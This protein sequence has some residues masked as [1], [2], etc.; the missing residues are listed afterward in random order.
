[1]KLITDERLRNKTKV[2]E[3]REHAGKILAEHVIRRFDHAQGV[4]AIPLGGIPVA[5]EVMSA[6]ETRGDIVQVARLPMPD[7]HLLGFGAVALT[8]ETYINKELVR[9]AALSEDVI[10]RVVG[11]ARLKLMERSMIVGSRP[12]IS[13]KNKTAIL[14]DDGLNT[15]YTM[16]A[17]VGF[18]KKLSPGE[19][20]LAVPTASMR[21]VKLLAPDVDAVICPNIRDGYFFSVLSAYRNWRELPEKVLGSF[22]HR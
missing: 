20:V 4:L 10:N 11:E 19:V 17:A 15:G 18:V 21:G 2:F 13:L 8:G 14:V 7:K 9:R 12:K 6:L 3:N 1:M 22:F 5:R 16:K